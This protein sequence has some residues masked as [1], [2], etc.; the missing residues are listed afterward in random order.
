LFR[1]FDIW[2]PPPV[3]QAENLPGGFGIMADDVAAGI[4]GALVLFVAGWFN[5]Y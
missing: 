5:L 2:K 3:R 1:L 4:Y